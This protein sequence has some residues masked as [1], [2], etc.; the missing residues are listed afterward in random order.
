MTK[1]QPERRARVIVVD[2]K[3]AMAETLADG[4]VD[5][6]FDAGAEADARVAIDA[7]RAGRVDLIV[8]DLRMPGVDGLEL[9]E[10]VRAAKVDVPVIVMTATVRST[11][12]SSRSA[13]A[14]TTTS[15]SRSSWTSSSCSR[16]ARSTIA[17]SGGRPP[18]CGGRS[19]STSRSRA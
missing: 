5:R 16:S 11:R 4:L 1:S 19:P 18:S 10:A 9:V 8:T 3:L 14:R 13:G 12:R 15:R 2:D 17:R 7:A 6:G